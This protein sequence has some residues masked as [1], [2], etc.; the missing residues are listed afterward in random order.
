MSDESPRLTPIEKAIGTLFTLGLS[1]LFV[2]LISIAS[3]LQQSDIEI[4]GKLNLANERILFGKDQYETK[5][6]AENMRNK[7]SNEIAIV[8]A[9]ANQCNVSILRIERIMEQYK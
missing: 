3:S 8:R 4:L 2:W 9:N 1:S 5:I 6:R 7:L